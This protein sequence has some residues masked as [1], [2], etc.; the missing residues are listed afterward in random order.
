MFNSA[1]RKFKNLG[2][3]AFIASRITK[4]L[5]GFPRCTCNKGVRSRQEY[6]KMSSIANLLL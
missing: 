6:I 5:F 4:F 2:T 3:D 1:P